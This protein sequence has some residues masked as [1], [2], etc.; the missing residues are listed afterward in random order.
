MKR[1]FSW[2]TAAALLL[3]P[4]MTA[5]A[6]FEPDVNYMALM[7]E[8]AVAGDWEAGLAA[9]ESRDEKIESLET[10]YVS[11]DF[12]ELL[13]LAKI[14]QA[15]AGSEW[16][17]DEWKMAVGEVVLNRV[18]SPEFPDTLEEVV[19]QPGQY[20]GKN[21]SFF[22][23]LLPSRR[24]A[25]AAARLLEGERVLSEPSVVFQANFVLGSGVFLELED[26]QLGSTYLC[27]SSHRELYEE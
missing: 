5:S 23:R 24:C 9:Q 7:I 10:A 15:E 22:N 20:Y 17:P 12:Q 1:I 8:A 11:V 14:I 13:L 18:A 27:Y 3:A 21:S 25:E 16:L 2:V 19:Y 26:S 4:A 6:D